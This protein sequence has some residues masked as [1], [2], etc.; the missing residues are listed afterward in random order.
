MSGRVAVAGVASTEATGTGITVMLAVLPFPSLV[1]VMVIGPPTACAVTSPLASTVAIVASLVV[2]VTV[3]PLSVLPFPSFSVAV[4]CCVAPT[5]MV[6]D[7]GLTST[8]ATG[9]SATNADAVPL[10]PSLVAV[11]V[12]GPPTV[13]VT[14]PFASTVAT[15]AFAVVP[16]TVRPVSGVPCAS[17]GVA[18]R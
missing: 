7:D 12:T 1:A 4:S 6:A 14:R 9:T 17:F 15:L 18:V 5:W 2:H 13:L 10:L 8:V 16:V 11:I 3:R